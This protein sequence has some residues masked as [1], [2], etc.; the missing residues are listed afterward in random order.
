M[1][2]LQIYMVG[3]LFLIFYGSKLRLREQSSSLPMLHSWYQQGLYLGQSD[4]KTFLYSLSN[5]SM[6]FFP[7]SGSN[8]TITFPPKSQL[9]SQYVFLFDANLYL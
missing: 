7:P 8:V 4:S 2:Y 6:T 1:N 5:F 9:S 3:R